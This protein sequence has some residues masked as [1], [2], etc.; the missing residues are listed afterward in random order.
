MGYKLD[1]ITHIEDDIEKIQTKPGMYI[2]YLGNR[3][4][5]HLS[6]EVINNAIDECINKNSPGD[7]IDITY[8]IS[9]DI[10][11]VEDNGRGLPP[12]SMRIACTK[13]NA[14]SKITRESSGTS[15]G[16]NG[17]GLTCVN[18]MSTIFE[19]K[20]FSANDNKT[21]TLEFN[22]GKET[23]Y[24]ESP[25]PSGRHGTIVRF[26][27]SQKYLGRGTRLPYKEVVEWVEKLSYLFSKKLKVRFEIWDDDQLI[28]EYKFK[29]RPLKD[30]LS[31]KVPE[32]ISPVISL[33]SSRKFTEEVRDRK[34]KR[35]ANLTICFCYDNSME[36]FN[37]SFCNFINTIDH[38]DHL[39]AVKEVMNRYLTN[40]TK[41]S[42]SDRDKEKLDI[43]W[44]DVQTG[45]NIAVNF[46]TDMQQLGFT[47]QT[48]QK[49]KSDLVY[50]LVKEMASDLINEFFD[51]NKDILDKLIK[52]IKL[53]AKAR[54]EMNKIKSSVVKE[55][56]DFW[57]EHQM[58]NFVPANNRGRN[59]RELFIVEGKSAKGSAA[60]ARDPDTQAIFAVKGVSANAINRD[61]TT[62]LDNKEFRELVKV[63]K[64]NI[65]PKFDLSKLNYNK[66]FIMTDADIDGFGI[67]SLLSAF[68]IKFL[69][70]IITA[71]KL[72]IAVPPLYETDDK[73]NPFI[74][75]THE[76][77]DRY[78]KKLRGYYEV[79]VYNEQR[80]LA[81]LGNDETYEF[82]YETRDYLD[83]LSSLGKHFKISMKFIERVAA[84]IAMY[85]EGEE[86]N[87][88]EVRNVIQDNNVE[89]L[90]GL[91]REFPEMMMNIPDNNDNIRF[92]GVI[93]GKYKSLEISQRFI[94]RLKP[95]MDIYRKYGCNIKVRLK[96]ESEK[97]KTM[98]LSEFFEITTKYRP[99]I[100][101]RFKGLGENDPE[102]LW[103]TTLNPDTRVAIQL[104][105][106]DYDADMEMF[107]IMHDDGKKYSKLRKEMMASY[108][109][110]RDDL[111]N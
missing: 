10:L 23:D 84:F 31:S 2:S 107:R 98:T 44:A 9:T 93:D 50:S 102:D 108:T 38:G 25:N 100:V 30:Y 40:A 64:C 39:D 15:A 16:E 53:N 87:V 91:Q 63:M 12:Q 37:D 88:D 52:I 56:T 111:D 99:N 20:V 81:K 69:P 28:E 41:K 51:G 89:L 32:S 58:D 55:S 105:I 90:S 76:Y 18:A 77:I 35:V 46:E 106:E 54:I 29:T 42:L 45:L 4:A 8:D 5:R 61:S 17:V 65:G 19:L 97:A 67:R 62:I 11:T 96:K 109:I 103:R 68:F 60:Q 24:K 43:C 104:K 21:Y 110:D 83:N 79:S 36:P 47:G 1:E 73:D 7:T 74:V 72:Y 94:H 6:F 92:F 78:I 70:D 75:D 49:V 22:E 57:K 48:K 85:T 14:G 80:K 95:L 26:A 71:G 59:Y 66:I 33:D 82:A 86:P 34:I 3:G 13:I 101:T 27:P